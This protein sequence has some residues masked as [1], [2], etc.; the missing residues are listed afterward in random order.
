MI[1]HCLMMNLLKKHFT[2]DNI[3]LHPHYAHINFDLSHIF[4]SQLLTVALLSVGGIK[5]V[6]I[7]S[8]ARIL[9]LKAV[10]HTDMVPSHVST[11]Q[12]QQ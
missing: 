11:L 3:N 10:N 8:S 7:I 4:D 5:F 1:S 2:L 9:I 6:R 12:K